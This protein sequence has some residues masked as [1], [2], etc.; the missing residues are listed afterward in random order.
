MIENYKKKIKG[1]ITYLYAW[2]LTNE[3]YHN[4]HKTF[5]IYIIIYRVKSHTR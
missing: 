5:I 4:K 3:L 2:S 1:E